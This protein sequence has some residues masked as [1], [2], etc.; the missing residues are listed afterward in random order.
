MEPRARRGVNRGVDGIRHARYAL[1]VIPRVTVSPLLSLIAFAACAAPGAAP[2]A[3]PS[4]EHVGEAL[5][6]R[7]V[8]ALADLA[9]DPSAYEGR[10]LLVEAGVAAVCPNA[11]CWMKI[12]DG[13]AAAIV[14]WETGCGGRYAFPADAAGRRVLV[15]AALLPEPLSE[16]AR[17]HL[18][19]EAGRSPEGL[20]PEGEVRELNASAIVLIGG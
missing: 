18:E 19:A 8:V 6:S 15:Q 13:D 12:E 2:S 4:G 20:L 17:A 11:G 16:D 3:P 5:E 7:E 14:R 10:T 9:R 1:P